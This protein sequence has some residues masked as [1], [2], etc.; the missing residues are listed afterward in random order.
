MAVPVVWKESDVFISNTQQLFVN[1]QA[2]IYA[3][4]SINKP[5]ASQVIIIYSYE[6]IFIKLMIYKLDVKMFVSHTLFVLPKCIL[7]CC[8][9]VSSS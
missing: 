6:A 5:D 3:N 9:L 8:D 1:R 7:N 4:T 2:Y